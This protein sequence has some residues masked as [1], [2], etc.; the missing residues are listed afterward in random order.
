MG[1]RYVS[2]M[3]NM[4]SRIISYMD[5]RCMTSRII[6]LREKIVVKGHMIITTGVKIPRMRCTSMVDKME[7]K[8][9]LPN[10]F[11]R[12]VSRSFKEME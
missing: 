12:I 6:G 4:R 7:E 8:L 9:L 3:I 5:N 1:G 2:N 10:T 11:L